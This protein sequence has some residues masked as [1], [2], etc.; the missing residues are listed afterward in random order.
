MMVKEK[1]ESLRWEISARFAN[2]TAIYLIEERYYSFSFF[3]NWN[4]D[5]SRCIWR[6][7]W[8]PIYNSMLWV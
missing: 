1:I 5:N 3:R 8:R 2:S 7:I 4:L 6:P